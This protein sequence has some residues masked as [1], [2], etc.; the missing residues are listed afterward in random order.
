MKKWISELWKL[1]LI[2][3]TGVLGSVTGGLMRY[4][5]DVLSPRNV[6]FAYIAFGLSGAFIFAFYHVRGLLNT[7]TAAVSAGA[8]QFVASVAYVPIL[9]S[10]IWSFGVN[11][12]VVSLAFL[13]E[14]KLASFKQL[15]FLVVGL[16]YGAL[17]VLLT[18]LVAVLTKV[19]SMPAAVFRENFVDGL[20]IGLGLGLG[21]EAGESFVHSLE[22]KT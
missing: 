2:T 16:V 17:F 13:F 12:A 14:R 9:N 1:G 21:V 18:L 7:I 5:G 15:K 10:A 19:G 20:L 11:L 4:G 8:V 22:K 3:L 6:A